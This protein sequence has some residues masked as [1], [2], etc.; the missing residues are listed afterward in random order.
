MNG[1]HASESNLHTLRLIDLRG[2]DMSVTKEALLLVM[3]FI[4][5]L[6]A[7][8]IK[9]EILYRMTTVDFF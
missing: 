2:S 8:K 7:V 6:P 9:F 4:L 1:A 5:S 3:S